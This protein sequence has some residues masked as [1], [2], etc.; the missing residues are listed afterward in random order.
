MNIFGAVPEAIVL[1][2]GWTLIHTLWEGIA[3]A[4]VAAA[5]LRAMS[6]T[7]A[8][9]RYLTACALMA[10]LPLVV[11]ATYAVLG[12]PQRSV[13]TSSASVHESPPPL[14][15]RVSPTLPSEDAP[16]SKIQTA[17]LLRWLVGFWVLGVLVVA[18]RHALGWLLLCRWNRGRPMS[19]LELVLPPLAKQLKIRREVRLIESLRFDVPA[20][21]G[22]FRPIILL[23]VGLLCDL[24]PRQVEL[25][26]IHE[27]AHIARHDYLVNLL[28]VVLESLMFYHP[29]TWW[30]SAHIRRERE[31]CCDDIAANHCSNRG[32]YAHALLSLEHRR[33]PA[34]SP[35]TAAT[36]GDLAARIRRLLRVDDRPRRRPLRSMGAA[37]LAIVCV[38]I[39][40]AVVARKTQASPPTAATSPT[41]AA[42]SQLAIDSPILP[43]DFQPST[44]TYRILPNDLVQVSVLGLNGSGTETLRQ[45][46]I[47][48]PEGTLKPAKLDAL[49]VSGM[50][51]D[52]LETALNDAYEKAGMKDV[53][54]HVTVIEA[55]GNT[56]T[57][58]GAFARPG[59]Y[60]IWPVDLRLTGALQMAGA[61]SAE[62]G[63]LLVVRAAANNQPS[64]KLAIN[65]AR[66]M[67]GA[68]DQDVAI[69]PGDL[70]F[71][72]ARS[73]PIR[74]VVGSDGL[75]YQDHPIE[76]AALRKILQQIPESDRKTTVLEIAAATPDVTVERF[77]A[78]EAELRPLVAEFRL[79]KISEIGVEPAGSVPLRSPTQV[80][81]A[82]GRNQRDDPVVINLNMATQHYAELRARYMDAQIADGPDNADLRTLAA[83]EKQ[84]YQ[85]FKD[86]Q[87][88]AMEWNSK[89]AQDA[90]QRAMAAALKQQQNQGV[91]Y[92]GGHVQ[93]PGVYAVPGREITLKQAIIAAGSLDPDVDNDFLSV[94]RRENGR[95]VSILKNARYQDLLSGKQPDVSLHSNDTVMISKNPIK[96]NG[97]TDG[98]PSTQ[99]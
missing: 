36:G 5:L 47:T 6:P 58:M 24:T 19:E 59:E 23:P 66:L 15:A 73:A 31:H 21:V 85:E 57:A 56:F 76:I 71:A 2:F 12:T 35:A 84:A 7:S 54:A 93:R 22:V 77:F 45:S 8:Q 65:I 74:V 89:Q 53:R 75:I 50:T 14:A 69:R 40:L 37:L 70:I 82:S 28:Q 86:A 27:L 17:S 33:A 78:A 29:A 60:Q 67:A 94:E 80:G 1:R 62:I 3:I 88:R 52:Q 25:I 13:V 32:E 11:L 63:N 16:Q 64:R 83:Q 79:A 44:S 38:A 95:V 30:L 26:L 81:E 10:L 55:R 49:K 61:R 9:A 98:I 43:E 72:E 96:E 46:R 99:K 90:Q 42:T 48:D 20:V 51:T 68:A 4:A 41:P 92:I 18:I 34:M 39:V 87:Q 91:Y 97:P